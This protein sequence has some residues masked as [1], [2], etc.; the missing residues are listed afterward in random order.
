MQTSW[1]NTPT[2]SLHVAKRAGVRDRFNILPFKANMLSCDSFVLVQVAQL[3]GHP[4]WAV[5]SG[6]AGSSGNRNTPAPFF[7]GEALKDTLCALRVDR[8]VQ[9]GGKVTGNST[10]LVI[11]GLRPLRVPELV[12]GFKEYKPCGR[13]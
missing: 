2:C 10:E 4:E 12:V 8:L 5:A 7:S 11:G 6:A 3:T 1:D 13:T 9:V